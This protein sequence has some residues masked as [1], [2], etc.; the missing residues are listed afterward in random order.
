MD[1]LTLG[2]RATPP[3]AGA[4]MRV[5]HLEANPEDLER[6]HRELLR[7]QPDV[8]WVPLADRSSFLAALD[9]ELPVLVLADRSVPG[10]DGL[11][12]LDLLRI[13]TLTVPFIFVSG[14]AGEELAIDTLKSGATDYVL[15]SR[16][17]R[18]GPAVR[19]ALTE[20]WAR[21]ER[22]QAERALDAQR[23]LLRTLVDAIPD[24]IYAVDDRGRLTM[25]NLALLREARFTAAEALG[26]PLADLPLPPAL[27]AEAVSDR[28]LLGGDVGEVFRER[29]DPQRDGSLRWRATTKALL[30]EAHS[31][32]VTG[33]VSITRDVTRPKEL[34]RELLDISGREQ[35]RL[36][37]DLHDD[38]GQ[39]LSGILMM[40]GALKRDI[41]KTAPALL[42]RIDQLHQ[43]QRSALESVRTLA[44]GLCPVEL[45]QGGLPI[46]LEG[47]VRQ[48]IHL[49]Q[50]LCRLEV[51]GGAPAGLSDEAAVHVFRIAQE[52]L[53]NAVKH[54]GATQVVLRLQ[55]RPGL[56]QL[57][58]ADDGKGMTMAATPAGHP[59]AGLGLQLMRYRAQ[60]VGAELEF[61]QALPGAE[62]TGTRVLLSLALRKDAGESPHAHWLET[63]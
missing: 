12:A 10:L 13:R 18:L 16:L 57:E 17:Q 34:E 11:E 4:L 63:P 45:S 50:P 38:I 14:S 44:R 55:S 35:R 1:W 26:R 54:S 42:E 2:T 49:P 48:F 5:F 51:S 62:R 8:E 56:L 31:D 30:R 40:M 28:A 24:A 6:V 22:E 59:A 9:E 19:R 47:L 3:V 21:Q 25:A 36:G 46:A 33:L 32:Q 39:Q 61:L 41:A 37:S 15:K 23:R 60:M 52:A 43:L 20:M 53:S 7:T 29:A 27:A 58:V